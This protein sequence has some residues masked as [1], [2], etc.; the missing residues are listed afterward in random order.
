MTSKPEADGEANAEAEKHKRGR[1]Q[2]QRGRRSRQD[3][4][5]LLRCAVRHTARFR[6]RLTYALHA[7]SVECPMCRAVH[8]CALQAEACPNVFMPAECAD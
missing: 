4:L 3:A 2:Q 1:R 8:G 6:R 7:M 5:L